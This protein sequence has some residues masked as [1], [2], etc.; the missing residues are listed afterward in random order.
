M[1]HPLGQGLFSVGF[2][3]QVQ[4]V[5]RKRSPNKPCYY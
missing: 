1:L 5:Y 3:G 2:D 4:K